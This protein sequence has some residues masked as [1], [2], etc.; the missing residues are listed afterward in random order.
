MLA[1]SYQVFFIALA[2]VHVK[3]KKL[4]IIHVV[5]L[6]EDGQID[7]QINVVCAED[8]LASLAF[9]VRLAVQGLTLDH[10]L[11]IWFAVDKSRILKLDEFL[12]FFIAFLR[13]LASAARTGILVRFVR[14]FSI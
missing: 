2:D 11:Q 12:L 14:L 4:L 3:F 13:L 10:V 6:A 1:L 5:K 7:G 9:K 8:S